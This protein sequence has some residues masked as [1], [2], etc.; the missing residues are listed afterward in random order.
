MS[1]FYSIILVV[2]F[3]LSAISCGTSDYRDSI[4]SDSQLIMSFDPSDK[5]VMSRLDVLRNLAGI[6]DLSD[7][8]LDISS[9]PYLFI[10]SVGNIGLCMK[11]ADEDKLMSFFDGLSSKPYCR[12]LSTRNG[13][14]FYCCGQAVI[15]C[16]GTTLLAIGPFLPSAHSEAVGELAGYLDSDDSFTENHLF[17]YLKE[18]DGHSVCIAAEAT[19]LPKSV[20]PFL[21][22]GLPKGADLSSCILSA[23]M[24]IKDN[25]L[26]ITSTPSS[27]D[28]SVAKQLSMTYASLRPIS[29]TYL[30]NMPAD[31]S[32]GIFMNID[33][34]TFFPV[35]SSAE[36]AMSLLAGINQ[37]I[38]F[39]AIF[40]SVDG[41]MM[42]YSVPS[43]SLSISMACQLRDKRFL[44]D[45]S[46]WKSSLPEGYTLLPSS[47]GE[48]ILRSPDMSLCFGVSSSPQL[49]FYAGP[50]V[51]ISR[52]AL[53]PSSSPLSVNVMNFIKGKKI[54]FIADMS[55]LMPGQD[56]AITIALPGKL[57]LKRIV[58]TVK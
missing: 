9:R 32:F 46:Y 17:Q 23:G 25:T 16:N 35:I 50:S 20:V 51:E 54:G 12:K 42:L 55:A 37:A 43:P 7:C 4:P 33:G 48:Y 19:S 29:A 2:T 47:S 45:V 22:L 5:E 27:N 39:N 30:H 28:K 26:L 53:H 1:K 56:D 38:D 21:T 3:C 36:S 58:Y 57:R 41:D 10:T 14:T 15:G 44:G 40:N 11:V 24:D 49:Q 8:G 18:D 34:K 52:E 6:E 31:V 13:C